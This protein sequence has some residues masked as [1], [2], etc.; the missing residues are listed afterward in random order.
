MFQ[1]VNDSTRHAAELVRILKGLQ[2]RVNLIRFHASPEAPFKTC[3][4]EAMNAFKDYLNNHGITCTI[5]ASR[6]EDIMAA[7][8][9]LAGK[10]K[11]DNGNI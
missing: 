8:G 3:T 11:R 5:R 10:V 9:L 2:C 6:G 1:G 7:C 4:A